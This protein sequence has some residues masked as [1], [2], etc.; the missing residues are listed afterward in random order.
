MNI[1]ST[2]NLVLFAPKQ[3]VQSICLHKIVVS[4]A[5][6]EAIKRDA[7]KSMNAIYSV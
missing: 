6:K 7:I 3:A 5:I 1:I 4:A 2:C